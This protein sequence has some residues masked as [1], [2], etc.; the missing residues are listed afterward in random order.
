MKANLE[1]RLAKLEA[2]NSDDI[3]VRRI[4][5]MPAGIDDDLI[6]GFQHD[7]IIIRREIG[8]SLESLQARTEEAI[9]GA[10]IAII[11]T[12]LSE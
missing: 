3:S 11:R 8:E 10:G 1:R 4:Y 6:S 7:Q 2:K 12:I 9:S 5:I